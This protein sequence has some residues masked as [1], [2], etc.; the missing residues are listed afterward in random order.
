MDSINNSSIP[1]VS[2]DD[3]LSSDTITLTSTGI[4]TM[5]S[6]NTITI[7]LSNYTGSQPSYY[8]STIGNIT[9][10]SGDSFNWSM[11]ETIPF[12]NGFPEWQ[13][14]QEM[15]KEYPGLEKTLEHLKSFYKLCKDDWETKKRGDA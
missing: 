15:C 7:D 14:F 6:A 8:D 11:I 5:S 13:D 4:D 12:E 10:G 1:I 2:I 3:I 9:L